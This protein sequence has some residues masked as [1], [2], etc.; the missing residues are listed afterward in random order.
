MTAMPGQTSRNQKTTTA[1]AGDAEFVNV[2]KPAAMAE[3]ISS[4]DHQNV[5]LMSPPT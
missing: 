1:R 4:V 5:R 3:I 2:A